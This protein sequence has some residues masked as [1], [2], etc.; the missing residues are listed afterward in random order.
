M[1]KEEEAEVE[2]SK[3]GIKCY[4]IM[5]IEHNTIGFDRGKREDAFAI[6]RS[7]CNSLLF[8]HSFHKT[9]LHANVR[10]CE[11]D[12]SLC[13][14]YNMVAHIVSRFYFSL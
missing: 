11:S 10:A 8:M 1:K 7:T 6:V 12:V 5:C 3:N 9:F 2:A 13:I 4:N 14:I